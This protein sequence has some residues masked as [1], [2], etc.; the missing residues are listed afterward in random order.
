MPRPRR[1]SPPRRGQPRRASVGRQEGSQRRNRKERADDRA[2]PSMTSRDYETVGRAPLLETFAP[3]CPR[4]GFVATKKA[5]G[6]ARATWLAGAV[7]DAA[8]LQ[9]PAPVVVDRIVAADRLGQDG[10]HV[11]YAGRFV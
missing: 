9:E 3:S 7:E 4:I 10:E 5:L 2:R 1:R 11:E 6:R 8:M